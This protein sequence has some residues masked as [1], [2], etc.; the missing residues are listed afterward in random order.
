MPVTLNVNIGGAFEG[1]LLQGAEALT[2]P[3][4]DFFNLGPLAVHT[5]QHALS[6]AK[7]GYDPETGAACNAELKRIPATLRF[8]HRSQVR[9]PPWNYVSII[10][11]VEYDRNVPFNELIEKWIDEISSDQG[12]GH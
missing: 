5:L 7:H 3:H 11:C 10:S 6:G 8:S 9:I 1:E 4:S 12:W 2:L